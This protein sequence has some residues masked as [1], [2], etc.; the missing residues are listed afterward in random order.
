VGT[1]VNSQNE[2][3]SRIYDYFDNI[4][5]EPTE[6]VWRYKMDNMPCGIKM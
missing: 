4:N 6:F 1:R 2:L 5:K 3:K